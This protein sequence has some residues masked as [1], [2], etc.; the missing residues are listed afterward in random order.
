MSA[1][2]EKYSIELC[3]PGGPG[4]GIE[5]VIA[6]ADDLTAARALYSTRGR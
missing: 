2:G 1:A 3:L 4:V 6:S 5:G